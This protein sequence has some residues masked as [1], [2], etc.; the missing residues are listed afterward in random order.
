MQIIIL[1][2]N[3]VSKGLAQTLS[4][5]DHDVTVVGQST[6]DLEALA[7]NLD[8]RV[9]QGFPSYPKVLRK[10]GAEDADMVIAVTDNDEI[11]M[12]ACEVAHALFHTPTK[13]AR[14]R[15]AEYLDKKSLFG[16]DVIAIDVCISPEQMIT[17]H[18]VR[19][20]AYPGA[21]QVYDFA[22]G[23][24][25]MVLIKPYYGG[26]LIGKSLSEIADYVKDVEVRVV[27][28]F[29]DGH[30]IKLTGDTIIETGDDLL[31]LTE[32]EHIRTVMDALGR[33]DSANNR[34]MIAGGGN[35]GLR[36]AQALEAKYHVKLIEHNQG[37]SD[38][39]ANELSNTTVLYGDVSDKRLLMDENIE[40]MDVF[41]AVTNDDEANIMSCMQ[42]KRLGVRQVIALV[43]R[44]A[45]VDLIEGSEID[46]PISPQQVT[47]GS[48]LARIRKGDIVKV[49]NLPNSQAEVLEIVVHGDESSSKV[50]GQS[51][52]ELKLP[53]GVTIAGM[54]RADQELI[55]DRDTIIQ[56][57]DHVLIFLE[58]TKRIASVEKLFQV[59]AAF[60]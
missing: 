7:E 3:E 30:A 41:C 27:A 45:Y 58:S 18:I 57:E 19:L 44:P 40:N 10:A 35:I 54:V 29:R 52:D 25:R 17:D 48:I 53:P 24:V 38:H 6:T 34:I 26:V 50:V 51:I 43:K 56:S 46:I 28:I 47:V 23:K 4:Q 39:I 49:Y 20:I 59:S 33:L 13:I 60:I 1:G 8:I 5:E 55:F 2:D 21:L 11:N 31:F 36:L 32:R 15:A 37:R 22:A 42:A 12:I 16:S 14:I 9:I